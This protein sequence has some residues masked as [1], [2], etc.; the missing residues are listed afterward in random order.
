MDE[1]G[2]IAE[3]QMADLNGRDVPVEWKQSRM[4]LVH[5]GGCKKCVRNYRPIA[6]I[7]K[8]SMMMVKEINEINQ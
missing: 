4:N 1:E 2:V 3:Y 5:K 7:S 6:I 8:V